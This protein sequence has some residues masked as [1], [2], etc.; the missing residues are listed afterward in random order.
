MRERSALEKKHLPGS[1]YEAWL[2]QQPSEHHGKAHRNPSPDIYEK[3]V[4]ERIRKKVESARESRQ[5][6]RHKAA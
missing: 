6:P 3:W 1:T 4:S 2:S 5:R